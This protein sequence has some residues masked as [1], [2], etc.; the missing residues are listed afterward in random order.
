MLTGSYNN[1]FRIYDKNGKGDATLQA[2][3]SA[4]KQPR[5]AAS[6]KGKQSGSNKPK[7]ADMNPDTMDY[8]KKI[9]HMAW[10]PRENSIAVA[11][12]NNL[13]TFTQL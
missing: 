1:F 3:K 11:A 12:T 13:F 7:K 10:H 2:D 9:L 6:A 8:T 4:F 5:R